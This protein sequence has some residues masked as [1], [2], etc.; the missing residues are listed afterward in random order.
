MDADI[1]GIIPNATTEALA[2]APP[3]KAF[4]KPRRPPPPAI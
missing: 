4:Y 1:Y 2:K 3:V